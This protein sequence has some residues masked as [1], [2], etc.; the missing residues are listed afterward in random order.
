MCT[1]ISHTTA[2]T[3]VGK[4]LRGWFPVNQATVAF[5]HATHSTSEHALLLDFT[6]YDLG[7]EARVAVEMDLVSGKAL[8]EQLRIA[9]DAAEATGLTG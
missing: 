9:I 4:G 6:N 2:I 1:S 7:T 8:I 5:D 3:G